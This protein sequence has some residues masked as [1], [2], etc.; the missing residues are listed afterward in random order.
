MSNCFQTFPTRFSQG[1]KNLK[2]GFAHTK[3]PNHG[4]DLGDLIL[5]TQIREKIQSRFHLPD[6]TLMTGVDFVCN[7][8]HYPS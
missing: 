5:Q 6:S 8:E 7:T 4:L 3:S 2:R 1:R